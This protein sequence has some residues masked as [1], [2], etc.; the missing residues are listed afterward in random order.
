MYWVL[1]GMLFWPIGIE[2]Q[3]GTLIYVD[4]M[5]PNINKSCSIFNPFLAGISEL[6][7]PNNYVKQPTQHYTPTKEEENN[8]QKLKSDGAKKGPEEYKP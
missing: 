8:F 5:N 7:Y 6:Y 1:M 3:S 2:K 4:P